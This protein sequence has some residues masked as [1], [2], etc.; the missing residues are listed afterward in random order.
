[1]SAPSP[2]ERTTVAERRAPVYYRRGA[3]AAALLLLCLGSWQ[4]GVAGTPESSFKVKVVVDAADMLKR[5][6]TS[7]VHCELRDLK[8][9][10][11]VDEDYT[12]VF[13]VAAL[14]SNT[15]T[16]LS[17]VVLE[18][19][20]VHDDFVDLERASVILGTRQL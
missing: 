12:Y 5:Q 4:E 18:R 8:D 13:S 17:V 2:E 11:I 10:T 15:R 20:N 7:Y 14:E 19:R 16:A 6:L 3:V 9:V 1:L